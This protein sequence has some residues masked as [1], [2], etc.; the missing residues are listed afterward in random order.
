VGKKDARIATLAPYYKLGYMYHNK[1]N[2]AP[3]E[4]Q[5]R[6]FPRSKLWD[7]MDCLAN[8]TKVMDEL[9][10]YFD[11]PDL[12]ED[13]EAEYAELDYEKPIQDWRQL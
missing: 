5:L 1:F 7:V 12:G 6:S 13:D 3:L 2:C 11:P 10:I 9:S 8:I 4:V